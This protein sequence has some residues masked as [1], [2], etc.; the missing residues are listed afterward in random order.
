MTDT[1]AG[2]AKRWYRDRTSYLGNLAPARRA[3]GL[4][5]MTAGRTGSTLLVD[6]LHAHP[7]VNCDNEPLSVW[8]DFPWRYVKGRA[9]GV[10]LRGARVY[11]FKL[12]T[13]N[14]SARFLS[15]GPKRG[16]LHFVNVLKANGFRF[17]HLRRRNVLR[18]AIS[19]M[20]GSQREFHYRNRDAVPKEKLVVDVPTLLARMV[21]LEEHTNAI[22][23]MLRDAPHPTLWYENDLER[24]E[25]QPRAIE[26][27]CGMFGL[28]A[29]ATKS[30]IVKVAPELLEDE[31]ENY[32]E[33]VEVVGRTRFSRFL[34]P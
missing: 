33:V 10:R 30:T 4:C 8:R 18:Q 25:D 29:H 20:R 9:R 28:Q 26:T 5:I 27:I 22:E 7:K 6:L 24:P 31:V 11:G 3:A 1:G 19:T 16:V 12:N 14:L 15:V 21:T 13:L 23:A 2:I 17:V 34:E 32:D